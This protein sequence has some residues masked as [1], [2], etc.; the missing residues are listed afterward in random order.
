MI[1]PVERS[2]TMVVFVNNFDVD[3][4]EDI[5]RDALATATGTD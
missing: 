5:T 1:Y 2:I 3:C 4:L